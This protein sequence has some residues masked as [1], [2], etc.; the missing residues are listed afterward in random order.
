MREPHRRLCVRSTMRTDLIFA[1]MT[2][3]ALAG[4]GKGSNPTAAP[5][6]TSNQTAAAAG[7][8]H[9]VDDLR[10]LSPGAT[11]AA[12]FRSIS[13]SGE[14]CTG[15]TKSAYQQDFK[16]MGMWVAHC[17]E[18]QDWAVFVSQKGYVQPR[19]CATAGQAGF[20]ACKPL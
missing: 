20:P 10:K 16:A 17:R 3:L 13:D 18:G 5:A 8:D 1:M 19:A 9:Y 4:C 2:M 15:V 12:L 14:S 6:A 7:N 11:N